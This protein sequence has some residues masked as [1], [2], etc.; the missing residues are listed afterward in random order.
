[1]FRLLRSGLLRAVGLASLILVVSPQTG[2]AQDAPV[3]VAPPAVVV[4]PDLAKSLVPRPSVGIPDDPP[5]HEGALI[6]VPLTL[7]PPDIIVVEVLE[8]LPGRPITGER[9]VRQDGTISLGFYGDV[10][11]R[12]LTPQQAKVKILFHL[13]R[14]LDDQVLGLVRFQVTEAEPGPVLEPGQQAPG[15]SPVVPDNRPFEK[16]DVVPPA[17]SPKLPTEP[18]IAPETDRLKESATPKASRATRRSRKERAARRTQSV[19][20]VPDPAEEFKRMPIQVSKSEAKLGDAAIVAGQFVYTDPEDSDRLFVD[21]VAHNTK[22]YYVQGDVGMPG[23]LPFTG[24][25]TVLDAL[26]YAKGL[27]PSAEPTDIHLYRPACGDKPAKEYR[28]DHATILKGEAKANLQMFP[29]DRLVIG[30]NSIVKK[31]IEV[32]RNT[33]FIQSM[34]ANVTQM[35]ATARTAN[36][37][38]N[39]ATQ[40][41]LPAWYDRIWKELAD[42]PSILSNPQKL[43]NSLSKWLNPAPKK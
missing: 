32:N 1:M 24:K 15:R 39:R 10:H 41:E 16:P 19:S 5:P 38:D 37:A 22:V 3:H 40:V 29:N 7:E 31:T 12:G 33:S 9:L 43:E 21:L 23:S 36:G 26:N 30:R 6:D 18:R 2:D 11:V 4:P 35:V 34:L 17:A 13:R 25:D 14:Y 28:I 8:A 42:D 20:Q 27:I